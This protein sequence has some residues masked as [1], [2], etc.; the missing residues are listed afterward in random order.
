MM[1][2]FFDCDCLTDPTKVSRYD[3]P[4]KR[5]AVYFSGKLKTNCLLL[6]FSE[7]AGKKKAPDAT[8]ARG[9]QKNKPYN[10]PSRH[11]AEQ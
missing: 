6:I 8:S 3:L 11:T 4:I 2:F 10:L 1:L 9:P 5:K 7:L